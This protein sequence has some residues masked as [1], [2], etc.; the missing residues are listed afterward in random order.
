MI[1]NRGSGATGLIP[2][3]AVLLPLCGG[4]GPSAAQARPQ[5][6]SPQ[7]QADRHV[8][9]QLY[10]PKI[11][12]A[13]VEIAGGKYEMTHDEN[14]VWS[15]TVGPLAPDIYSYNFVIDDSLVVSDPRN[16]FIKSVTESLVEVPA[17]PLALWERRDVPHGV[18]H[19]HLYPSRAL[20]VT[21]RM[22]V[23]T[24]PGYAAHSSA[25]YPV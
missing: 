7:V 14:G 20:G 18:V 4:A 22:H 25:R 1:E 21:R 10:A 17:E 12:Q 23:Y 8:I 9:F 5:V 2:L 13:R 11:S 15:A 24:P 6:R 19:V 3:L 16:E